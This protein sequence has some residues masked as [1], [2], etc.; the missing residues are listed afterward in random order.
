MNEAVLGQ[1]PL[2]VV[3]DERDQGD[4]MKDGHGRDEKKL[5]EER[6]EVLVRELELRPEWA[7]VSSISSAVFFFSKIPSKY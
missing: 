4:K 7:G 5:T 2:D 3:G 1:G 6:F